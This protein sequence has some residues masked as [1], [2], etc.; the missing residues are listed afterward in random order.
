[1]Y[2]KGTLF[3]L[4]ALLLAAFVPP[5]RA[6]NDFLTPTVISKVSATSK[7]AAK[8]PLAIFEEAILHCENYNR[9]YCHRGTCCKWVCR[10]CFSTFDGQIDSDLCFD[11]ICW[12]FAI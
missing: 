6:E 3:L 5:L 12:D 9:F 1:M 2:R 4:L 7:A 10:I 11:G 8:K